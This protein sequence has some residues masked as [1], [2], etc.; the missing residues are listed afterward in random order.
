MS[1]WV[2]PEGLKLLMVVVKLCVVGSHNLPISWNTSTCVYFCP[3][4]LS[5]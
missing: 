3:D 5:S 1:L 4:A 2:L